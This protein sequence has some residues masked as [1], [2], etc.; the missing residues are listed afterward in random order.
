MFTKD[1]YAATWIA[2]GAV[3]AAAALAAIVVAVVLIRRR[4]R[5]RRNEVRTVADLEPVADQQ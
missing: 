4:G 5:S 1:S 2:F 3:I